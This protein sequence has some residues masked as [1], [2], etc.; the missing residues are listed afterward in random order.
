[1]ISKRWA[2]GR[3]N[4]IPVCEPQRSCSISQTLKTFVVLVIAYNEFFLGCSMVFSSVLFGQL[5]E[6]TS[7]IQL[8]ANEASWIASIPSLVSPL[9]LLLIGILTD[10]IG[11]RKALQ[12]A[13]MPIVVS[14][15]ILAYSNSYETIFIGRTVAGLM[16]GSGACIYVYAAE[17]CPPNRR[18]FFFSV[19]FVFLGVGTMTVCVFALF[20]HWKTVSLILAAMSFTGLIALFVLP[21]SPVW[22]REHGHVLEAERAEKWY[23]LPPRTSS[24]STVND[25]SCDKD[26]DCDAAAAAD[27][28]DTSSSPPTCWSLYARRTVWVPTLIALGF[29]ACQQGSGLY[30]MLSYSNDILRNFGIQW[31]STVITFLMSISRAVGSVAYS[32]MYSVKRKTMAAVS[33][34]GMTASSAVIIAYVKMFPNAERPFGNLVLTTAFVTYMF[35]TLMGAVPLPWTLG[36]EIFP[37][38][39]TASI[40]SLVSPWLSHR[41]DLT[42]VRQRNARSVQNIAAVRESVQENPRQ[43]IPRRAQ[44]LGLSQSLTWRILRRDL[45]LHPH[46]IQL[47]QELKINDHRQRRLFADWVSERLEEDPNFGRKVVFSDEAHFW[48][49]GYVNKQNCRIWDNTNPHEELKINDHRQRQLFADWVLER[50]EEDPNFG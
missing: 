41:C 33:F 4:R 13:F 37:S 21:D 12:I 38:N 46:K 20:F 1:M 23:G 5:Q 25:A 3:E 48:M 49:N 6:P 42:P 34:G 9:G 29:F 31:D 11:R 16:Y 14:F 30:V 2:P 40:L 45:G 24:A 35:F 19:I 15:L 39:V 18:Q 17:I 36:S 22:L 8:N 44:E 28:R 26:R 10:K 50:L 47:T 27:P 32:L 43:S 7:E